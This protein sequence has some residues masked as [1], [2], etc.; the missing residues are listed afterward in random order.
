MGG[1]ERTMI[2][3]KRPMAKRIF[4][5]QVSMSLFLKMARMPFLQSQASSMRNNKI[6]LATLHKTEYMT[7][8]AHFYHMHSFLLTRFGHKTGSGA[9]GFY[10]WRGL[11]RV[12]GAKV[13]SQIC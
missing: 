8:S 6:Q 12:Q 9:E 4:S 7:T 5:G 3:G 1:S 10:N 2:A 13:G 11:T